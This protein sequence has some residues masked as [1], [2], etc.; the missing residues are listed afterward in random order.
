M[1]FY[2]FFLSSERDEKKRALGFKFF[3]VNLQ[4][5]RILLSGSC[6]RICFVVCGWMACVAVMLCKLS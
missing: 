4:C 1:L 2:C 3:V 6:S 5:S